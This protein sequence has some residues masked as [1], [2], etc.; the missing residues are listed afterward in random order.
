MDML[1]SPHTS[2]IELVSLRLNAVQV[3]LLVSDGYFQ[4]L[5]LSLIVVHQSM[6]LLLDHRPVHSAHVDRDLITT[7]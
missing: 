6:P 7:L 5:Y 2:A 4:L 3:V 1:G